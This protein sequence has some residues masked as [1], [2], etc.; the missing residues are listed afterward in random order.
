MA[1]QDVDDFP[2]AAS[3][4]FAR[5]SLLAETTSA[6]SGLKATRVTALWCGIV[7]TSSPESAR[8]S[9]VLPSSLPAATSEP[10]GLSA[11]VATGEPA[12]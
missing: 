7:A 6:P 1:A 12:A 10:S 4:I 2:V 5:R 9:R 11:A 3:A 8:H